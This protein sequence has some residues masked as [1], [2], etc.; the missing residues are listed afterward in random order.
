M[1][2]DLP[3]LRGDAKLAESLL[4]QLPTPSAAAY[5]AVVSACARGRQAQGA[6][7]WLEKLLASGLVPNVISRPAVAVGRR[8]AG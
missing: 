2:L 6:E 5:G 8:S 4:A 3:Q 7:R 1:F